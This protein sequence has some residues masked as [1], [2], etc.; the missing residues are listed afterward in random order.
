MTE[1]DWPSSSFPAGE[2]EGLEQGV[3][4]AHTDWRDVLLGAGFGYD[5]VAHLT[6]DPS[7]A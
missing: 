1:S 2:F 5:E 6:W 3:R 7:K 4:E